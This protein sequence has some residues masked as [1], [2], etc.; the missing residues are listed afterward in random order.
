MQLI[1]HQVLASARAYTTPTYLRPPCSCVI[2]IIEAVRSFRVGEMSLRSL[3]ISRSLA[4]FELK[5]LKVRERDYRVEGGATRTSPRTLPNES[6]RGR[7]LEGQQ[8]S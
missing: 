2:L 4:G 8:D 7:F 3:D 5:G 1:H 6:Q